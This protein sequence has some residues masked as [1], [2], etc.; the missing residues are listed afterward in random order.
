MNLKT[1]T[2]TSYFDFFKDRHTNREIYKS[3]RK[4]KGEKGEVKKGFRF[5]PYQYLGFLN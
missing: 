3:M 5:S 1:M 4:M 2:V